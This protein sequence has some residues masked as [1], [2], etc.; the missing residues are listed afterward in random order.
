M[1]W[2]PSSFFVDSVGSK[3]LVDYFSAQWRGAGVKGTGLSIT[4]ETRATLSVSSLTSVD[5]YLRMRRIDEEHTGPLRSRLR[6]V[7]ALIALVGLVDSATALCE[8]VPT[9][10]ATATAAIALI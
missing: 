4:F 6:I 1:E 7:I 3:P 8:I 5:H 9:S 10:K 2:L